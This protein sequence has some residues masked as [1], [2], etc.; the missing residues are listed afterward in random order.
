MAKLIAN[1]LNDEVVLSR[2]VTSIG[3]DFRNGYLLGEL[4]FKFKQQSRF[5]EFV[6]NDSPDAKIKNFCLLEPTFRQIGVYFNSKTAYEI[7]NA[8]PGATKTLL[9][10]IKTVLNSATRLAVNRSSDVKSTT[11]FQIIKP[12]KAEYD[13][14]MSITFENAVRGMVDNPNDILMEK[15]TKHYIEMDDSFRET[16]SIGH[17]S[18]INSLQY[19]L[20]RLKEVSRQRKNHEREF[21][22]TWNHVAKEQWK[23][24]QTIAKERRTR[25]SGVSNLI[26][27]RKREKKIAENDG[28]RLISLSGI[29]EFEDRL[30]KIVVRQPSPSN[31]FQGTVKTSGGTEGSGLPPLISLDTN[32]LKDEMVH[33]QKVMKEKNEKSHFKQMEHDRRRKKFVAE[34]G[35]FNASYLQTRASDNIIKQLL[36]VCK[37]ENSEKMAK[38]K[39]LT[40]KHVYVENSQY[41]ER[42]ISECRATKLDYEDEWKKELVVRENDFV[43]Q[44]KL[45]AQRFRLDTLKDSTTSSLAMGIEETASLEVDRVLDIVDWI[46]SVRKIGNFYS[47][48]TCLEEESFPVPEIIW[49]DIEAVYVS[50]GDISPALQMPLTPAFQKYF[51]HKYMWNPPMHD[52]SSLLRGEFFGSD[53]L[54]DREKLATS[55]ERSSKNSDMI[56]MEDCSNFI[57]GVTTFTNKEDYTNTVVPYIPD[58]KKDT[59][60]KKIGKGVVEDIVTPSPIEVIP[61]TWIAST[62]YTCILG[63]VIIKSRC[64]SDAIPPL[65]EK[66]ADILEFD[67][68]IGLMGLSDSAR[69]FVATTLSTSYNLHSICLHDIVSSLVKEGEILYDMNQKSTVDE[70]KKGKTLR[71]KI[72]LKVYK[73]AMQ[74]LPLSDNIYTSI[75]TS[76]IISIDS[77][78]RGFVLQDYPKTVQQAHK[79]LKSLSGVDYQAR[80]P[81][82]LDRASKYTNFVPREDEV[83]DGKMCGLDYV[84][85]FNCKLESVVEKRARIRREY[86]NNK[87]ITVNCNCES[88]C[89]M[90]EISTPD[91][92]CSTFSIKQ[93]TL[94]RS[95]VEL[96]HFFENLHV[97]KSFSLEENVES[98]TDD[99]LQEI[100][101]K[102]IDDVSALVNFKESNKSLIRAS[103][104]SQSHEAT[105]AVQVITSEGKLNLYLSGILNSIWQT[106]ENQ[107]SN[108]CKRLFGSFRD[109]RYQILQRKGAVKHC[110]TSSLMRIDGRQ[111]IYENFVKDFNSYDMEF[112]FDP[113]LIAEFNLRTLEMRGKLWEMIEHKMKEI[114]KELS[115]YQID[116]VSQVL[117]HRCRCEAAALIQAYGS[118]YVASQHVIF[119][120]FRSVSTFDCF[121]EF[122]RVLEDINAVPDGLGSSSITSASAATTNDKKAPKQTPSKGKMKENENSREP[123]FPLILPEVLDSLPDAGVFQNEED[124]DPKSGKKKPPPKVWSLYDIET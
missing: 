48:A 46:V 66:P 76:E 44:N 56:V 7:I 58:T 104:D 30:T 54:P 12:S 31:Q 24:N 11:I 124:V 118:M 23:K 40:F 22:E 42:L 88:V 45:N 1:W 32:G 20:Q 38:T 82:E 80:R 59:G 98:D 93:S 5:D 61:P 71:E 43:I 74:G 70:A 90:G 121:H 8:K 112:R 2:Q 101:L 103:E 67:I 4:L 52:L 109:T 17:M 15:A 18:D 108:A 92:P 34:K 86:K 10:E 78:K 39:T 49:R 53:Y 122:E 96:S 35:L 91:V 41:R 95:L 19:D 85:N 36:N 115:I 50:A 119:D 102:I 37:L 51:P 107:L 3:E 6:D 62:P 105:D 65:P 106:A 77:T 28:A 116:S 72:A 114:S 99:G 14:T 21:N 75:V 13:K 69:K 60:S 68:R 117:I 79:L 87:I 89:T 97:L 63:E 110:I 57:V 33:T 55:A 100:V 84:Y 113:D 111:Q 81:Q 16:V 123:V 25:E 83:Y 26:A 120:Y 9:Y 94:D 64:I 73:S 47:K 27:A 29:K